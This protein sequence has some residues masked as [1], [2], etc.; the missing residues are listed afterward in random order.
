MTLTGKIAFITAAMLSLSGCGGVKSAL[1]LGKSAPDEFAVVT[2]APL[3]V[4]PDFSLRPP[5]PGALRPQELQPTDTARR[6]LLGEAADAAP[7]EPSQGEVALLVNAGA[8]R[9]DPNIRAVLEEESGRLRQKDKGF[10]DKILFWRGDDNGPDPILLDAT[11]ESQRLKN[12]K[13]SDEDV[14]DDAAAQE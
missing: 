10:T 13:P 7:G 2:K 4:P 11:S 3:I 12:T 9:V 14:A 6:V 8:D 1:G 5:K